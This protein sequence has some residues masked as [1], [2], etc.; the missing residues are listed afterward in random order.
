MGVLTT[1]NNPLAKELIMFGE[2]VCAPDKIIK[3]KLLSLE[4]Q[5]TEG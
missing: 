1:T 2:D 4:M 3:N 5:I